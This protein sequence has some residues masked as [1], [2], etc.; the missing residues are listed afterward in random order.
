MSICGSRTLN[1][2]WRCSGRRPN[3]SERNLA[4]QSLTARDLKGRFQQPSSVNDDLGS[5]HVVVLQDA[6][7]GVRT[8]VSRFRWKSTPSGDETHGDGRD[9]TL[10]VIHGVSRS[11]KG[12]T[13]VLLERALTARVR[14]RGVGHPRGEVA[15]SDGV[16]SYAEVSSGKLGGEL[17]REGDG[18]SPKTQ[19]TR[20]EEQTWSAKLGLVV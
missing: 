12:N 10:G 4:C 16:D 5:G 15:G 18:R 17:V 14:G 3:P 20:S 1:K 7:R 6:F 13:P 19:R 11:A 2:P 9:D 8:S